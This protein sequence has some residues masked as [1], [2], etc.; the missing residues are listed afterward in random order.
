MN[1]QGDAPTRRRQAST[2]F[3]QKRLLARV[4]IIALMAVGS[5]SLWVANPILWLWL[6]SRLESGSLTPSMGPYTLLLVGIVLTS[7]A[8]G[9]GLSMLNRL[10]GRISG[11]APTVR[12]ILPWRR[13][14]RGGR[15]QQRDSDATLPVSLLDVVMVISVAV[16]LAAFGSWY[17]V[18]NPVP[19]N[20]GGPGPAK[21]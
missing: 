13:S 9:K 5:I 20:I 3:P 15:S 18:T 1:F 14:L 7:V 4:G 16:A 11:S 19:P 6:T 12:V 21:H 2:E 8:I 10:Y 17:V